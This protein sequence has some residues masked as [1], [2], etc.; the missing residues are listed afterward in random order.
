MTGDN[1]VGHYTENLS[2]AKPEGRG[3]EPLAGIRHVLVGDGKN[4]EGLTF[5]VSHTA[6]AGVRETRSYR[7]LN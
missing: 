3:R 2:W 6:D 1:L 4:R 5:S 7:L